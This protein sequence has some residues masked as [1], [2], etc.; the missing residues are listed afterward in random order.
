MCA[1]SCG[2][3]ATAELRVI[4]DICSNIVCVCH[5]RC[6]PCSVSYD[7]VLCRNSYV[8]P[9]VVAR[10]V[11]QRRWTRCLEA[12]PGVQRY[13]SPNCVSIATSDHIRSITYVDHGTVLRKLRTFWCPGLHH[14]L[15][16][17]IF[18][19]KSAKS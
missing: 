14:K 2:L 16:C 17:I 11:S 3:S 5:C 13:G 15:A 8:L 9:R 4:L 6:I 10:T 7:A 18:A 1:A 19:A 12:V